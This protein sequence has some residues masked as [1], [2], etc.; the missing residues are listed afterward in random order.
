M[1]ARAFHHPHSLPHPN[2]ALRTATQSS[3]SSSSSSSVRAATGS[4]KAA[5]SALLG[6]VNGEGPGLNAWPGAV[7]QAARAAQWT[8]SGNG[9]CEH[10][11]GVW[12][13]AQGQPDEGGGCGHRWL[14]ACHHG[15][16]DGRGYECVG[17]CMPSWKGCWPWMWAGGWVHAMVMAEVWGEQ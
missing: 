2:P 15:S 1:L 14:G 11:V 7:A 12:V 13:D 4:T 3:S 16:T 9:G 8:Q 6:G 17:G 10:A 5:L